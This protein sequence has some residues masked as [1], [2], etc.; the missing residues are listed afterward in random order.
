[1]FLFI[2]FSFPGWMSESNA[3]YVRA[4]KQDASMSSGLFAGFGVLGLAALACAFLIV[5]VVIFLVTRESGTV[6]GFVLPGSNCSVITCP[7]GVQGLTGVAGP[8][9]PPG[10]QGPSGPSG[11]P[12][13]QGN[14]GLP[15][16]EGP[17]GQ[18]SNTN[19]FCT[20]GAT[21]PTGAQGIPG[22]TGGNGLIGPTGPPGVTGPQGFNGTIG[23]TGP[24]GI[25]GPIGPN[26]TAGV[27]NCFSLPSI[28]TMNLNVTN[29]LTLSGTMSCPGGALGPDCFGLYGACP[30]FTTCYLQSYG[31][32]AFSTNVSKIPAIL[33]GFATGD[34]GLGMVQFGVWPAVVINTFTVNAN[35]TFN[36]AT[37][38]TPMNFNSF[39]ANMNLNANGGT[40]TN[41]ALTST[42][43]I[44]FNAPSGINL[45][46]S[47]SNIDLTAGGATWQLSNSN[48]AIVGSSSNTTFFATDFSVFRSVGIPWFN[49]Q[50]TQSLTC[51]ASGPF[52]PRSSTSIIWSSDMIQAS[53]TTLLTNDPSGLI[54]TAGLNL[55]GQIIK[56][57]GSTLQLQ[58]DTNTRIIDIW[59][60]I[61][62]SQSPFGVTIIDNLGGFN[63]QDTAFHNSY[64][65]PSPVVCDDEQGLEL[66]N[67][68][69]FTNFLAPVAANTTIFMPTNATL[70]V[71]RLIPASGSNITVVGNLNVT[72]AVVAGSG[73]CCVSDLRVKRN[74]TLVKPED[75]LQRILSFPPRVAFQYSEA[76]QAVDKQV[77]SHVYDSFVAQELEEIV[78]RLVRKSDRWIGSVHYEDFRQL[79]LEMAV[80]YLVGA[81]KQLH[82]DNEELR[83]RLEKIGG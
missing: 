82:A 75:D 19:P 50:S 34:T 22:Q 14:P 13:S 23:P 83:Q 28:S 16:P 24:I 73:G 62:N 42:G 58:N 48:G 41:L 30:N 27:C 4:L 31:L 56:T 18:C 67:G 8:V 37:Q 33:M 71:N 46:S 81:I 59:G 45:V 21:G 60:V 6:A 77:G 69:L 20:Q 74:I 53:G 76:Y 25:Q 15:G 43:S 64:G 63:L 79:Q 11:P 3:S 12:G 10:L 29:S 55:C 68:T 72:G 54:N 38:N 80:P 40:G 39:N 7:A 26:G 44:N 66:S 49:T 70:A 1:M 36:V 78:P 61:T 57:V 17:M 65:I 5:F 9:G 52:A 47:N 32:S 35:G 51:A 2:P